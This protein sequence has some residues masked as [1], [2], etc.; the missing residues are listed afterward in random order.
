M[1]KRPARGRRD[2]L[3]PRR[4][5]SELPCLSIF[6]LRRAGLLR[7]NAQG[8]ATTEGVEASLQVRFE[9]P[10]PRWY[11][12]VA[13]VGGEQHGLPIDWTPCHFGGRR[14]WFLCPSCGR[15]VGKLYWL[16]RFSRMLFACRACADL[17][18]ETQ[19]QT[20]RV[21][22]QRNARRLRDRLDWCSDVE[23]PLKP[24]GMK[25]ATFRRVVRATGAVENLLEM[26]T[27]YGNRSRPIRSLPSAGPP[28][29]LDVESLRTWGTQRQ[30][31]IERERVRL[32]AAAEREAA[33][34]PIHPSWEK[35]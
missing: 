17:G 24:A 31:R 9:R 3:P 21:R 23:L 2:G 7:K 14:P 35:R 18:Y 34:Y 10:A 6:A 13:E 8:E 32:L 1:M 28:L 5:T 16:R 15:R 19:N 4:R 27:L 12:I 29:L 33:R 20:S 22:L 11:R 26:A 25:W 30:R